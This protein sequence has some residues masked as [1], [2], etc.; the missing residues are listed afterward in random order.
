[1]SAGIAP[2]R[3]RRVTVCI[4]EKM[5]SG[6]TECATAAAIEI[7]NWALEAGYLTQT[8]PSL[9]SNLGAIQKQD[10]TLLIET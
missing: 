7:P 4:S 9:T 6:P 3:L 1:M 8:G 10:Y 5:H 2:V